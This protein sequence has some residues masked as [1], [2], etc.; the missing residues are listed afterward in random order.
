[1]KTA[2]QIAGGAP[3]SPFI[4]SILPVSSALPTSVPV[5]LGDRWLHAHPL[6]SATADLVATFA[7]RVRTG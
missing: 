2:R 4:E 5:W 7:L 6:F 1:V 3:V